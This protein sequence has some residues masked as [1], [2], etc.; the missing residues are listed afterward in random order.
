MLFHS[1]QSGRQALRAMQR[2]GQALPA[3]VLLVGVWSADGVGLELMLGAVAFG[4]AV[5]CVWRGSHDL[6]P[7]L[8]Q[9]AIGQA[10]LSGPGLR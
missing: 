1:S 7:L 3:D 6:A 8:K 2:A 10:V 9:A 4:T 5:G